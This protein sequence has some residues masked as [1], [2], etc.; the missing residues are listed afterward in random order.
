MNYSIV[1]V[2]ATQERRKRE[3]YDVYAKVLSSVTAFLDILW[4]CLS[5]PGKPKMAGAL[6]VQELLMKSTPDQRY[7]DFETCH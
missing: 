4:G 5:L 3:C 1:T 2:F 7:L 6:V